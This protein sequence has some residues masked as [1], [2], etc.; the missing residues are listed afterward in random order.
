MAFFLPARKGSERVADKNTRPFAGT[1]GGLIEIKLRQLL[2]TELVD[3]VI[4]STNDRKCMDIAGRHASDGRLRI[5]PRPE[6][7]CLGSTDL[8]DLIRYVPTITEAEHI[9]WGHATTPLCGAREYDEGIR[10]YLSRLREG[11]DSL[12]GVK[13]LRNFLFDKDGKL[14]NN[15]T[16]VPW[17]RTQDL[18]VLYEVNHTMFLAGREVYAE[19]ENRIGERPFLHVMDGIRS[20]DIDWEEDFA[21]AEALYGSFGSPA[22]T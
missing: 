14:T 6:G 16:G 13:E 2:D 21:V 5:V 1:E 17:P 15:T 19:R 9:L 10:V 12:V 3:E 4:L 18:E 20:F 22:A 11:Y 8:Q 7:L